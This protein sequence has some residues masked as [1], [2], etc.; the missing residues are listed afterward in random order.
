VVV[1]LPNQ[2]KKNM[3]K[4]TIKNGGPANAMSLRDYLAAAAMQGILAC[5]DIVADGKTIA[6]WAYRHADLMISARPKRKETA[7]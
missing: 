4:K 1:L 7:S 3:S 5:P 6:R 2:R